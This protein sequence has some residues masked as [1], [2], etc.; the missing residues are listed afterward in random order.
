MKYLIQDKAADPDEVDKYS[1]TPL[2]WASIYGQAAVVDILLVRPQVDS[3]R[4]DMDGQTALI[5]AGIYGHKAVCKRLLQST[6]SA[7]LEVR[8]DY[9]QTALSMAMLNGHQGAVYALLRP[10]SFRHLDM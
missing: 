8:D 4:R 7:G 9:G 3:G 10:F 6:G 5:W 2:I 1:R